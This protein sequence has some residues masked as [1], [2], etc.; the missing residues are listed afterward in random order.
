MKKILILNQTVYSAENGI[1]VKI[2]HADTLKQINADV[3]KGEKETFVINANRFHILC[4]DA[5]PLPI[6][7]EID[8][9]IPREIRD[10][11][12]D[13]QMVVNP[14]DKL[15][16]LGGMLY[17]RYFEILAEFCPNDFEKLSKSAVVCH[18]GKD[19][20]LFIKDKNG[21]YVEEKD[22]INIG[23]EQKPAFIYHGGLYVRSTKCLH[24]VRADFK[25]LVVAE[26]YMIFWGGNHNLFCMKLEGNLI[27]FAPLGT[28][29]EFIKTDVNQLLKVGDDFDGFE[30]YHL[31]KK[32]NRVVS[33]EADEHCAINTKTGAI[34]HEYDFTIDGVDYP[35]TKTFEFVKG[36]YIAKA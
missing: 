11:R 34:V 30:I 19:V 24:F 25:P 35:Q 18:N 17:D 2:G 6:D 1:L 14:F 16:H 32:L 5:Y 28:F 21:D 20:R 23:F 33:F 36:S 13:Y 26:K 4:K 10:F 15:S 22:I 27:S 12:N 29:A 3:F 9:D 31:G 7:F 8:S